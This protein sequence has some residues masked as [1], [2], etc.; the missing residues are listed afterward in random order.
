LLYI[1]QDILQCSESK[2]NYGFTRWVDPRLIYPQQQYIY[3]LQ[4]RIFNLERGVRSGYK[5]DE[6]DDI[7]NGAGSQEALYNDPY[8]TW[9]NHKNQG[10]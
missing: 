9:P 6:D 8:Y 7:N 10:P 4:D 2:E 5:D 3:Y 1:L